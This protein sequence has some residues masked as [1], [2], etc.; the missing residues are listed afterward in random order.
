MWGVDPDLVC[1]AGVV[2]GVQARLH[3]GN[4]PWVPSQ[5]TAC[6]PSTCPGVRA[7]RGSPA[8]RRASTS[9]NS[10][11]TGL[12][13]CTSWRI[14][15]MAPISGSLS[16]GGLARLDLRRVCCVVF[17][18]QSLLVIL[19]GEQEE[20]QGDADDGRDDAGGVG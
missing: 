4:T 19:A 20:H 18:E 9:A 8:Q 15:A 1:V 6:R 14:R 11:S 12:S 16:P 10:G 2:A 5:P 13:A 3:F 17:A 7:V